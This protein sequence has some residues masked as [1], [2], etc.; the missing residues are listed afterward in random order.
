M[1]MCA[2]VCVCVVCV[3]VFVDVH[4]FSRVRVGSSLAILFRDEGPSSLSE[5]R[6][7]EKLASVS[8]PG[9][10]DWDKAHHVY[11]SIAPLSLSLVGQFDDE[12][13]SL[14]GGSSAL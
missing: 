4:H 11:I 9:D 8:W 12:F 3:C 6:L 5:R 2:C 10:S 13:V 1:S 7:P 14:V